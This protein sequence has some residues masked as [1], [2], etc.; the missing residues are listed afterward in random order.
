MLR[1][2]T[3]S[4]ERVDLLFGTARNEKPHL[5][6]GDSFKNEIQELELVIDVVT[7]V[8]AV[9]DNRY[10]A[11]EWPALLGSRDQELAE[12]GR[13]GFGENAWSFFDDLLDYIA[14]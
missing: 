10:G 14:A 8:K 12:L 4:E 11:L 7:L 5:G 6:C 13:E 1:G 3:L 9:D 2:L